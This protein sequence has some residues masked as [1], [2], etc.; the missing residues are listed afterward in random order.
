MHE[1]RNA[2]VTLLLGGSMLYAL[3]F[4][5]GLLAA[6]GLPSAPP[7]DLFHRM[8]S[9]GLV[10]LFGGVL[11]YS[12]KF[13]DKLT[14]DLAKKTMG[15][16]YEADGLCFAPM[17]R[18]TEDEEGNPQAEISLYYQNRYSNPCEAVIHLRPPKGAVQSH[19][20]ARDIHFAFTAQ[21]GAYGVVHQ[22]VAVALEH[23]G[24]PISLELAAAVRFPRGHGEVLRSKC[25]MPCGT[26]DVDWAMAYRQSRH[27]LGG[28]IELKKPARV[29]LTMPENVR[30]E[31]DRGSFSVEVISS[32]H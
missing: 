27:E 20:G 25:G 19:R 26:F 22:P 29:Q 13:E 2:I 18:M 4:W 30:T 28:E 32:I 3:Y 12:Y 15:R 21:P 17:V 16:Y 9:I 10:L 14:D 11:L 6:P 31:I 1:R 8:L 5:I 24:Q 7:S 23:Q